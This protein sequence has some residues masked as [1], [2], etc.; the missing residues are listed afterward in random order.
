VYLG[1]RIALAVP[2]GARSMDATDVI[3]ANAAVG[4]DHAFA[5]SLHGYIEGGPRFMF[6]GE[7]AWVP[8]L[9]VDGVAGFR[10]A[11]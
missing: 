5:R 2:Y 9:G 3:G 1:G 11:L 7:D 4:L 8:N 6:E 10:I